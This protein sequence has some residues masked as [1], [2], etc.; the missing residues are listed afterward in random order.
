MNFVVTLITILVFVL[1]AIPLAVVL[2][3]LDWVEK[4]T[5]KRLPEQ[6]SPQKG[7]GLSFSVVHSY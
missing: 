1:L 4:S 3:I 5:A 2:I 7:C 6:P